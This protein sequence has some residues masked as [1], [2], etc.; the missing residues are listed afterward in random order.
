[1]HTK[2]GQ[3]QGT[4]PPNPQKRLLKWELD[5]LFEKSTLLEQSCFMSVKEMC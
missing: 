2:I 5:I 4:Q 1:M 3:D